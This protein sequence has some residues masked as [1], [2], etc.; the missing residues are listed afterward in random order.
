MEPGLS[1]MASSCPT[2]VGSHEHTVADAVKQSGVQNR[3]RGAGAVRGG[4]ARTPS[5]VQEL[6]GVADHRS[7]KHT[8]S[9]KLTPRLRRAGGGGTAAATSAAAAGPTCAVRDTR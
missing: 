5:V 9:E 1:V 4:R 3:R 7:S 2:K 6:Q 8:W